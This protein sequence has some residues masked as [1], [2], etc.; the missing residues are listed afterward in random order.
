MSHFP[1]YWRVSSSHGYEIV[2]NSISTFQVARPVVTPIK[3][4]WAFVTLTISAELKNCW[5]SQDRKAFDQHVTQPY[6]VY[7]QVLIEGDF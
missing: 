6:E 2:E 4:I 5:H 1:F 7:L 3:L